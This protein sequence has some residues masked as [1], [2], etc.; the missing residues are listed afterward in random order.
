VKL[1]WRA[2]ASKPRSRSSEG[3]RRPIGIPSTHAKHAQ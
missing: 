3:S 1:P 2:A